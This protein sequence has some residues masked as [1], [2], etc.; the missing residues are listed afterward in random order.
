MH[1]MHMLSGKF[2]NGSLRRF[3]AVGLKVGHC[4]LLQE[5]ELN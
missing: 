4:C 1:T 5:Y 2:S 3:D